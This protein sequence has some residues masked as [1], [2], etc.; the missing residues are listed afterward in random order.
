MASME[1]ELEKYYNNY[2]DLFRTNGW[3]QITEE[4]KQNAIA[5]NSVEA[6]KDV[7]DMYFRKGQLN[8]LAHLVNFEDV[9]NNAFDEITQEPEEV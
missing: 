1:P 3:K 7:D 9:I 2:F 5:I 8:V 6:I 4:L